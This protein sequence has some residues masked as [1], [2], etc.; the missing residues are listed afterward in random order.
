MSDILT[1][2]GRLDAALRAYFLERLNDLE[3]ALRRVRI[4]GV[5]EV[6]RILDTIVGR[7]YR[8]EEEAKAQ[9][10]PGRLARIA[11][12][13]FWERFRQFLGLVDKTVTVAKDVNEIASHLG[14]PS[15]PPG[16]GG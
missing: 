6:E 13:S 15:L 16:H 2:D 9:Q 7:G 3:H 10:K 4:V 12:S 11:G 5:A 14:L 1:M 8:E